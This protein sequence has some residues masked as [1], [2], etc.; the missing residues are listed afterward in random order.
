MNGLQKA[1]AGVEALEFGRELQLSS[2]QE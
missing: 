1:T 2:A